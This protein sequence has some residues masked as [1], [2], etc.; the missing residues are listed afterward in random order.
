MKPL[1]IL[2]RTRP[3]FPSIGGLEAVMLMLAEEFTTAGHQVTV[4]TETPNPESDTFP[5]EVLR[6]PTLGQVLR[7]QRE[8][9]VV[10]LGNISLWWVLELCLVPRPWI[11]THHGW[12]F[13]TGKPVRLLERLKVALAAFA[14]ANV[15][16]SEAVNRFLGNPGVVIPNPYDK[17]TFHLMPEVPRD[18]D[19]VFLG[20]LVSDKGADILLDALALLA[21]KGLRPGLTVI[22][23]GPDLE[24][25]QSQASRL[26]LD[27]QVT[28]TGPKRG[29][30]LA[31]LLNAHRIMV[32][33]SRWNEPFGV[34]ALEGIA[35]GC[36]IVASNGGGLP[37]AV[38]PCGVTFPNNDPDAL[39][40]RLEEMLADNAV[41][42]EFRSQGSA[43]LS[44][45]DKRR[46]S[47]LYLEVLNHTTC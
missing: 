39:A 41:C 21:R 34:V 14:D 3:F 23:S 15:S 19:L 27:Q 32:I 16:V 20:R 43:H 12:Y 31:R 6:S 33:P 7:A 42:Q 18:R 47:N 40:A 26:G 1:R 9:D 25:L 5:F 35:C 30:E 13:D 38:G 46:I 29:H 2:I 10:I 28:F 17:D 22:G 45:H 36:V 24:A 8:S 44:L 4:V 37:E 11:A